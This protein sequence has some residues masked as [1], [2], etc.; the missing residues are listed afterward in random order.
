MKRN[1]NYDEGEKEVETKDS[2]S[3]T[4]DEVKRVINE[5]GGK[6]IDLD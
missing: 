6:D 3:T 4:I 5:R 1:G 2:D